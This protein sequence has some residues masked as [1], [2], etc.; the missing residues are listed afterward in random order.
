MPTAAEIAEQNLIERIRRMYG[1]DSGIPTAASGPDVRQLDD[2]IRQLQER[3]DAAQQQLDTPYRAAYPAAGHAGSQQGVHPG[4]RPGLEQQ[5]AAY[6][7]QLAPLQERRSSL[8][9]HAGDAMRDE[10]ARNR[11][12]IDSL[13][14]GQQAAALEGGQSDLD[15]RLYAW[16]RQ[17][18]AQQ[19]AAGTMGGSTDA[20][21]YRR[22]LAEYYR[23]RTQLGSAAADAR[24]SAQRALEDQRLDLERQVR[25]GT[26][27][28]VGT[29]DA[30]NRQRTDI[31]EAYRNI[32]QQALGGL[33]VQGADTYRQGQVAEA[34]GRRGWGGTGGGAASSTGSYSG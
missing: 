22:G 4:M 31:A 5:I 1:I 26:A 19:G 23:G 27:P 21:G 20:A 3:I 34:Y 10:V 14:N 6:R 9:G 16:L 12:T 30:L 18:R 17:H 32:P 11:G 33:L 7:Q 8:D 24:R 2:A 15:S 28:D 25:L 29:I 13:L